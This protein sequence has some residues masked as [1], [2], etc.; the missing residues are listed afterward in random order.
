MNK[1]YA[2]SPSGSF[3][4]FSRASKT[5]EIMISSRITYSAVAGF[6]SNSFASLS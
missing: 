3:K 6:S 5:E 4:G 1:I 2:S